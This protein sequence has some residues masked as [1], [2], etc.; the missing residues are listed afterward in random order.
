MVVLLAAAPVWSATTPKHVPP[1][2]SVYSI[3]ASTGLE[4]YSHNPDTIRPPA[5]MIKLALILLVSEG[6]EAGRWT[7]DTPVT[8]TRHAEKMGGTQIYVKMG[9]TY[10][11]GRLM[12]GVAVASANDAAMAVAEGLWGSEEAYLDAA[13]AR[14]QELG[15]T[16]SVFRSVH[17]LPPDRGEQPDETT[18]RDMA[19]LARECVKHKYIHDWT[20]TK[21]FR[22]RPEEAEHLSTNKLMQQMPECDGLKTGYIAAAGFCITATAA[23]GGVRMITVIMGHPDNQQRFR[24]AKQLLTEGMDSVRKDRVVAKAAAEKP[25]IVIE[26]GK[27]DSVSLNVTDDVWATTRSAD[28][29]RIQIVWD[30][31]QKLPAPV[32]AGTEAGEVRAE[33]DGHVLGRSKIVLGGSVEQT[34]WVWRTE[35]LIRSFLNSN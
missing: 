29:D 9:E 5:S 3:E 32:T 11:L 8:A 27:S 12:L 23:R 31:P 26:N 22:F 7:L 13:N 16:R 30:I 1:E 20:S 6:I 24:L 19:T 14:I 10:P 25:Q 28:W 33:L 4:L 15:M 21:T 35:K 18:A 2:I 17:G 34:S